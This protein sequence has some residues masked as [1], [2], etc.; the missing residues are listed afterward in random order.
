MGFEDASQVCTGILSSS[1]T[2]KKTT[3][4]SLNSIINLD[5]GDP[6]MFEPYWRNLGEK[7]KL[8]ISGSDVMSY[9][10]DPGNICW[11]LEPKLANAI[12]VLHR[13]VG[14]AVAEDRHILVGTGSTQLFQAALFALS[15]P[16][17]PEPISVVSTAPYYSSFKEEVEFLRSG[18]YKWQGDAK[19]FHKEGPYIEVVTSPSNPDGTIR[20]AVVNR[21]GGKLIHDLAYYW[22]QY[23]PITG[24]ADHDVILFTFSKCTGH[25]GSR[26]G[27]AIVKDEQVARRMTKFMELSSIGVSKESQ[28]R[29]A[30]ILEVLNAGLQ[31]GSGSENFFE[32]GRHIMAK[33][34]FELRYIVKSNSKIFGLPEYP[35]EFCNFSKGTTIAHPAFA[36][37]ESKQDEDI[38]KLLRAH[39]MLCRTG[40]R[41]GSE[42]KYVRIS[43]LSRDEVFDEFLERLAAIKGGTE[44]Q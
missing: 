21:E 2:G 39:K 9:F 37:L 19:T 20:R 7:C 42:Q 3:A 27:W 41:F 22:P 24:A 5:H 33:R 44:N 15:T 28:L 1:D 12:R 14:N 26:I 25:A 17:A 35:V 4:L 29:A 18:L 10:S 30:K 16:D 34:W 43:M 11:F 40:T 38:E 32:Y 36:W 13:L 6:T 23:T 8:V 31:N